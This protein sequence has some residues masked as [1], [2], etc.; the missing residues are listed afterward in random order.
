MTGEKAEEVERI[1]L[2]VRTR[3]VEQAPGGSVY[4]LTDEDNGKILRISRLK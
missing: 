3:D 2:V 1:P 4:V